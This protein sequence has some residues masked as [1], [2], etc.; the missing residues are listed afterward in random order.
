[1]AAFPGRTL[2]NVDLTNIRTV[3]DLIL[4]LSGQTGQAVSQH[5]NPWQSKDRV[6]DFLVTEQ[7][8]GALPLN[9]AYVPRQSAKNKAASQVA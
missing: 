4:T 1:M 5:W 8:K 3:Q 9:V 7:D 6:Q 2:S